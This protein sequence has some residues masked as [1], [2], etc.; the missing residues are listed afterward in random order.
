MDVCYQVCQLFKTRKDRKLTLEILLCILVQ[1]Y[2][3][4]DEDF[5]MSYEHEIDLE[6]MLGE[7][8]Y[9][10]LEY[11]PE[12]IIKDLIGILTYLFYTFIK[13]FKNLIFH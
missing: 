12:Y 9:E 13:L 5:K 1:L 11:L 8:F 3:V 4:V 10:D 6:N 2:S 7:A